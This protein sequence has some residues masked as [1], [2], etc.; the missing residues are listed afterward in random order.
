M[1]MVGDTEE[2]VK[3]VWGGVLGLAAP[4]AKRLFT[5]FRLL[6]ILQQSLFC[7]LHFEEY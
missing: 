4:R 5:E 7:Y 3:D 2:D 1:V 6:K